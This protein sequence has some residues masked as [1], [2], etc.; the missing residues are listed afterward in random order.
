MLSFAPVV[1]ASW[2]GWQPYYGQRQV[3]GL[4]VEE[5]FVVAAEGV[6]GADQ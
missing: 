5:L 3:V 1:L 2:Q 4:V 6:G